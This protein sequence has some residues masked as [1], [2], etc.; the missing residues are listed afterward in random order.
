[1][2]DRLTTFNNDVIF[3]SDAELN[4]IFP[5]YAQQLSRR[6]WTP[7][8]IAKESALYLAGNEEVNIL[9]I[10]S[11]IGKFCLVGGYFQPQAL[12]CGVE[13]RES[14]VT[15]ANNT[16]EMLGLDNVS[17]QHNNF[18]Q[19]DFH[20]YDHF[21][22]YNSFYENLSGTDK[23]D[24]SIDYSAELYNYYVRYLYKQLDMKPEGTRLVTFHSLEDEVPPC[25]HVISSGRH[26]TLKFWVKI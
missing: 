8:Q 14:L 20:Q 6:H 10:G 24:D 1:M 25:Y 2:E 3:S 18:T 23:I 19:L 16:K 9:D 4:K 22:F 26:E 12:F 5:L 17:F 15:L 13:Q 11:G 7:L 21:Y